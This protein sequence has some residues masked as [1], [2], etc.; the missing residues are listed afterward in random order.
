MK[1]S[2]QIPWATLSLGFNLW[3]SFKH[4]SSS[5]G[6]VSSSHHAG[7]TPPFLKTIFHKPAGCLLIVC[8]RSSFPLKKKCHSLYLQVS[9]KNE[10][11][12]MTGCE[13]ILKMESTWAFFFFLV[14]FFSDSYSSSF[15]PSSSYSSF[16]SSS[17]STSSYFSSYTYSYSSSSSFFFSSSSSLP[18]YS[19]SSTFSFSTSSSSNSFS[20]SSSL[21]S[22]SF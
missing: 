20:S 17:S 15:S 5:C 4:T 11:H 3:A 22:S 6:P 16:S 2:L 19:S 10:M 18:S 14:L 12:W 7:L 21:S 1:D 8:R 13:I 9:R